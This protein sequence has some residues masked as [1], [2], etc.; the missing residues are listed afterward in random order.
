[1]RAAPSSQKKGTNLNKAKKQ[2]E[3]T[4]IRILIVDDDPDFA[5]SLA[6]VLEARGYQT[7]TANSGEA[8]ITISKKHHFDVAFIDVQ[9]NGMNGLESYLQIRRRLPNVKCFL[10]TGYSMEHLLQQAAREG[11]IDILRKPL[12]METLLHNLENLG[13]GIILIADDDPDFL[14]SL[15]NLLIRNG[16]IVLT[17]ANGQEALNQLRNQHV[18]LILLDLRM[19]ILDGIET[20][21]KLREEGYAIPVIMT[22]A[23]SAEAERLQNEPDDLWFRRILHKPFDPQKLLQLIAL[24]SDKPD[25]K[26]ISQ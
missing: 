16:K 17:A 4:L 1:M 24:A 2:M 26:E 19:P 11:I 12:N 3:K 15:K 22:T 13:S 9:L 6:M 5:D 21:H 10:M 18:D 8:A 25:E 14:Q 7:I 23:Y 20:Y